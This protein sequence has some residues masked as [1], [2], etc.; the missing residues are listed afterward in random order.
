MA[1]QEGAPVNMK[2]G[3]DADNSF[4]AG[5]PPFGTMGQILRGVLLISSQPATRFTEDPSNLHRETSSLDKLHYAVRWITKDAKTYLPQIQELLQ[6]R[7]YTQSTVIL[8]GRGEK[9]RNITEK[10]LVRAGVTNVFDSLILTK[11]S[12]KP[13]VVE[14]WLNQGSGVLI[15]ED[16]LTTALKE[17]AVYERVKE[18]RRQE[19]KETGPLRIYLVY[20]P[21]INPFYRA[22]FLKRNGINELPKEIK[23]VRNF[24]DAFQD[25]QA[26][27]PPFNQAA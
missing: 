14:D 27:L 18:Q 9:R 15:F 6:T 4:T 3:V 17:L 26:T 16:D 11:S 8:S 19:G 23:M 22:W 24:K 13:F 10:Q 20:N 5:W 7:G 21:W 12:Q 1:I 2:V 25:L